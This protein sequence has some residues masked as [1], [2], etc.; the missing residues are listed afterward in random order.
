MIKI[1]SFDQNDKERNVRLNKGSS[2]VVTG[3]EG[4]RKDPRLIGNS[5]IPI[6]ESSKRGELVGGNFSYVQMLKGNNEGGLGSGVKSVSLKFKPIGNDWLF[7]SAAAKLHKFME[8]EELMRERE[9]ENIKEPFFRSMGGRYNLI[10]FKTTEVRD[11]IIKVKENPVIAENLRGKNDEDDN[12]PKHHIEAYRTENGPLSA[13]I[14]TAING[15]KGRKKR[16]TIDDI[17]GFTRVNSLDNKSRNNKSKCTVYRSVVAALALSTCISS[18]GVINKNRIV[19]DEAQVI[20][21]CNKIMGLG[22]DGEEGEVISKF[23]DMVIEDLDR[24]D[25][26]AGHA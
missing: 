26:V 23:V 16:K 1:A 7:S 2:K 18:D 13:P 20:W 6:A 5:N 19:L 10:T 9:K 21:T 24:A 12:I 22:Y 4:F 17:L 3:L 11:A 15:V 8:V 14:K 25:K